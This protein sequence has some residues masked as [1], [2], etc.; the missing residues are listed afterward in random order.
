MLRCC[1]HDWRDRLLTPVSEA[2]RDLYA[3]SELPSDGD[4][5]GLSGD[6]HSEFGC[7][8]PEACIT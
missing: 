2:D 1:I 3:W 5:L 7:G 4:M 6:D 8:A